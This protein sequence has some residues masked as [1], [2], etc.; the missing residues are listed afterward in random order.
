MFNALL[1][2]TVTYF[3]HA[4]RLADKPTPPNPLRTLSEP[5]PPEPLQTPSGITYSSL[6]T[7]P[8]PPPDPVS[9]ARPLRI[10][11]GYQTLL[12][13]LHTEP[14]SYTLF[15]NIAVVFVTVFSFA[16]SRTLRTAQP[17]LQ[18]V[19]VFEAHLRRLRLTAAIVGA[20]GKD[21]IAAWKDLVLGAYLPR[22][23][24]Q[25]QHFA[26]MF[27][28]SLGGKLLDT[29]PLEEFDNDPMMA[30]VQGAVARA[31]RSG[32]FDNDGSVGTP[33]RWALGFRL[34]VVATSEATP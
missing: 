30:T 6:R 4:A 26:N 2:V 34:A 14:T 7:P 17:D 12:G 20:T 5:P 11:P 15:P 22:D 25:Y 16:K 29:Y 27:F 32:A 13:V 33:R 21:G 31:R 23:T 19:V 18:S 10:R 1:V 9:L 24:D 3:K 28:G 8:T